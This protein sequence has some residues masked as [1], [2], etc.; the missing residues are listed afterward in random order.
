MAKVLI[1]AEGVHVTVDEEEASV[2]SV[3]Y[4]SLCPI[5]STVDRKVYHLK[6]GITVDE[7]TSVLSP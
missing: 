1:E 5:C 7:F 4:I 6:S 2:L 3:S